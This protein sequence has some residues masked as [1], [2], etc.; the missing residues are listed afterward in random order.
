VYVPR[1][2]DAERRSAHLADGQEPLHLGIVEELLASER[3]DNAKQAGYEEDWVAAGHGA[4]TLP[5]ME[6]YANAIIK[7]FGTGL[8]NPVAL[9]GAAWSHYR[10][11]A[12]A[13]AA[14]FSSS[15]KAFIRHQKWPPKLMAMSALLA[16]H[17]SSMRSARKPV[18]ALLGSVDNLRTIG[19]G[20]EK[21]YWTSKIIGYERAEG[22]AYYLGYLQKSRVVTRALLRAEWKTDYARNRQVLTSTLLMNS[23]AFPEE[24]RTKKMSEIKKPILLLI[25]EGYFAAAFEKLQEAAVEHPALFAPLGRKVLLRGIKDAPKFE[26]DSLENI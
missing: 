21:A 5:E 24:E 19:A 25:K 2:S 14:I 20:K 16:M 12:S 13:G 1:D 4:Q 18:T 7:E 11:R 26:D 8:V 17:H 23:H 10:S 9:M 15:L 3:V 6:K 22:A